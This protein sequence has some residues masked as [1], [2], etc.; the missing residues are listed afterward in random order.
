MLTDEIEK[1]SI[2]KDFKKNQVNWVNPLNPQPE[3]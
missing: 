2:K 3:S 1:I